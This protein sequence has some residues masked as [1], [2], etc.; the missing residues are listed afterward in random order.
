MRVD[1]HTSQQNKRDSSLHLG[2]EQRT[3]KFQS[4]YRVGQRISGTYLQKDPSGL[5]WISFNG[6]A[7][8]TRLNAIP[9]P[10][11]KLYFIITELSPNIVLKEDSQSETPN[12]KHKLLHDLATFELTQNLFENITR[13]QILQAKSLRHKSRPSLLQ[14]QTTFL[15]SLN[16]EQM[17]L[18]KK[19]YTLQQAINTQITSTGFVRFF[20]LPWLAPALKL[21]LITR[22]QSKNTGIVYQECAL[23]FESPHFGSGQVRILARPEQSSLRV[24]MESAGNFPLLLKQLKA[25]M[26]QIAPTVSILEPRCL[27][28]I[29]RHTAFAQ[30]RSPNP[31]QFL[32][33]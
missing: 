4:I 11:T 24:F 21:N 17:Q 32:G 9:L 19:I 23:D 13:S 28:H 12:A 2:R 18:W 25:L 26:P 31:Q 33:L 27:Q 30:L 16:T 8:L 22:R 1:R 10:G 7:L 14:R 5:A 29:T 6:L 20:Y 3:Q 15:D